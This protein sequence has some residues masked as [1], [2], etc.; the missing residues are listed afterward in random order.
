MFTSIKGFCGAL[1]AAALLAAPAAG[2]S[3]D[4]SNAAFAPVSGPT[5]TPIG[6]A[7]F[8]KAHRGECGPSVRPVEAATL[9]EAS[10]QLLIAVNDHVN[11][12][13]KPVTDA[14]FY[15]VAEYWTYP[16]SGEGDC[17]DFA[18]EKRRLLIA[19]GWDASTLLMT[20]V[21]QANGEGHAVLMVRTDRG[22]LVLDNQDGRVL[23]W[24]DTPYEFVKRQ[25]QTDS[26]KWVGITDFR[27]PL[28]TAGH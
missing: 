21:R 26:R 9:T 15:K 20:V 25:S 5:S 12:T 28:Y 1:M 24:T 14:D 18:L 2:A 16:V 13:V 3:V 7:E 4:F 23:L 6:A 22:D 27:A 10:W 17:E 19:N 8:C 11:T